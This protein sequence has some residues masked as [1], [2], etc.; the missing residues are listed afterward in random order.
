M[1]HFKTSAGHIESLLH[2]ILQMQGNAV[3]AIGGIALDLT[4]EELKARGET[5][6]EPIKSIVLAEAARRTPLQSVNK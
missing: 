3:E 2:H 1:T 4:P 5:M 6:R